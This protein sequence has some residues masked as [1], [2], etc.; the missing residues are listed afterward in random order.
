MCV[1]GK[2]AILTAIVLALGGRASNTSRGSSFK[3]FIKTGTSHAKV[4]VTL[5]NR[6][7]SDLAS[8]F[9]YDTYGDCIIVE[10]F[11]K[12][13]GT[14]RYSIK[15]VNNR[16]VSN[17]KDELDSIVKHFNI[18]IDNPIMILNQEISRNFLNSKNPRD[19]YNFFMKATALEAIRNDYIKAHDS[20]TA[21]QNDLK[22]KEQV[23]HNVQKE[24][25]ELQD[26]VNMFKKIDEKKDQINE[27][28]KKLLWADVCEKKRQY[29]A[30]DKSMGSSQSKHDEAKA[31]INTLKAK[32]SKLEKEKTEL[33]AQLSCS[34]EEMVSLKNQLEEK[35]KLLFQTKTE[36]SDL[37]REL[38]RVK[39]DIAQHEKEASLLKDKISKLREQYG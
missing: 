33:T 17:K 7:G 28:E 19:K 34:A 31:Q 39:S 20:L 11:L 4:S 1:G 30:L 32:I 29:E 5:N 9:K 15:S 6:C 3:S 2:S 13:D 26:K 37:M 21:T 18:Q 25:K 36:K 22:K 23:L 8:S 16:L 27:L 10:R 38:N 35:K 14:S 12:A 24:L